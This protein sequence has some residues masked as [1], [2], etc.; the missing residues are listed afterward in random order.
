MQKKIIIEVCLPLLDGN[1]GYSN[2]QSWIFK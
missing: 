1:S 2:N